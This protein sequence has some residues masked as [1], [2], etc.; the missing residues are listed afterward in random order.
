MQVAL[1]RTPD[2]VL[3]QTVNTNTPPKQ[4][5]DCTVVLYG[6]YRN[7]V[8]GI[9]I[10]MNLIF[11][12]IISLCVGGP[13][14]PVC[15]SHCI[16]TTAPCDKWRACISLSCLIYTCPGTLGPMYIDTATTHKNLKGHVTAYKKFHQV[17]WLFLQVA[18]LSFVYLWLR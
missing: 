17:G 11:N 12:I 7:Q 13:K 15:G 3:V 4:A 18:E 9:I 1:T 10:S 14:V 5:A 2:F 6:I 16:R 8:M